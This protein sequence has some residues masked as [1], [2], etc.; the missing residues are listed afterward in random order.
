MSRRAIGE[1]TVYRRKDGR[2]EGAAYLGT[3]SGRVRRLRVY[4]K[5]RKEA[6]DKLTIKMADV[7]RGIPVPDRTWTVGDY[8][9]YWMREIAPSRLRPTTMELYESAIRLH[10]RPMV[11]SYTLERLNV[12][13]LQQLLNQQLAQGKTLRTVRLIRTILSAALTRAVREEVVARNVARLVELEA[14]KRDEIVPWTIEE[15]S[16]FLRYTQHHPLHPA[17]LMLVVYGVRRGE[18][19]GLR[20][21]DIDWEHNTIHIRQQ[22]QEIRNHLEVGP[23]KTDAGKRD[24]PL[25]P[26]VRIALSQ[27]QAHTAA[28]T[29]GSTSEIVEGVP[30]EIEILQG[31]GAARSNELATSRELSASDISDIIIRGRNGMPLWPRNFGRVF[32]KLAKEAGLRRVKLHWLRHGTATILKSLKVQPRDAQIIMGHAHISTTLQIYQH[33][34]P[35]TQKEA[36]DQAGRVLTDNIDGYVSRQALP[37]MSEVVVRN[38]SIQSGGSGGARTLDTLLKRR[39]P[40]TVDCGTTP[41]IQ[42]LRARLSI[43]FLGSLAVNVAVKTSGSNDYVPQRSN[44]TSA[45]AE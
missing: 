39:F 43:R 23:V 41:V 7:Q 14:D 26:V 17:F 44:H 10:L 29:L 37:S 45:G 3:V 5:T 30:M 8:L 1:G 16:H 31:Y 36:L 19:L 27:L 34:D 20:W 22:L 25:L 33:G 13:T 24:L 28:P 11:G 6:N 21:S 38:A 32:Q 2:W 15:A 4:G 42:Q 12:P 35:E 40:A 9:E 18:V